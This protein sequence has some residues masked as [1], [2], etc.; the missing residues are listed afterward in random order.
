MYPTGNSF[1]K[2][3]SREKL[4]VQYKTILYAENV[5]LTRMI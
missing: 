4:Y 2:A 5:K 1:I 3:T